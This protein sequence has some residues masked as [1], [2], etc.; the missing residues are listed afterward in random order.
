V[1]HKYLYKYSMAEKGLYFISK[2]KLT[3]G[4]W[5]VKDDSRGLIVDSR[6]RLIAVVPKKQPAIT[7]DSAVKIGGNTSP[8]PDLSE[9]WIYDDEHEGNVALI[10]CA[11]ELLAAL[12]EA[13]YHLDKAGIPLHD[14]Y[15]DLINRASTGV[16]E[17]RAISP[18]HAPAA[19][20][21]QSA[22]GSTNHAPT[23]DDC[24]QEHADDESAKQSVRDDSYER[25]L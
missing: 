5:R 25:D 18:G 8:W 17:I 11:P 6:D 20:N 23:P 1:S 13:A 21:P 14:E 10:A 9:E 19:A 4:H 15:Y 3:Y 22:H 16:A 24:A 2:Q 7:V 12:K